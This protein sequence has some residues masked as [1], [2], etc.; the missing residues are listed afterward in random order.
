MSAT[1]DV[2]STTGRGPVA[3]ALL[4]ALVVAGGSLPV[5][6]TGALFV[7]LS[8]DLAFGTV[9]LGAVV[10]AYRG[11]TAVAA[12]P[13]G[14]LA[15]R[16]RP[17][18][19]LRA[20][21]LLA[22]LALV[23]IGGV[24][25]TYV[26]LFA[27]LLLSG[28]AYALGQTA[29]NVFLATAVPAGR[30]GMALGVKQAAIPMSGTLAG[31][32]VPV[33]ALTLGWRSAFWAFAVLAVIGAVA[34]PRL[35]ELPRRRGTDARPA[36]A[37][38]MDATLAL[39]VALAF[40]I[41]AS[42]TGTAFL[43]DSAV[44]TGLGPGAAG[45][46]LALASGASITMRI[47]S[48]VL[49]D[50]FSMDPLRVTL[51]MLVLGAFGYLGLAL[52]GTA[53]VPRGVYIAGALVALTLGWGYNGVFWLAVVRH[54][55]GST[56]ASTGIILPMGMTG[57]VIGPLISGRLIEA[58]SYPLVWTIVASWLLIAA[59]VVVIGVRLLRAAELRRPATP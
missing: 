54:S 26:H 7:Q 29:V 14:R 52:G 35:P 46:L 31:L 18:R 28:I 6:L 53:S 41:A 34:V 58:T 47:V 32:A 10:G 25:Q 12:V 51:A 20:A 45:L 50:R 5:Y 1:Q 33:F 56:G 8:V 55:P 39:G 42:A 9:G 38:P 43:V 4:A 3:N 23:G 36:S 11:A 19:S 17:D 57:G 37:M 48:G 59:G 13:L 15:D 49:I 21:L 22:A 24:A 30:Q 40:G 2:P 44:G 16:V 27:F